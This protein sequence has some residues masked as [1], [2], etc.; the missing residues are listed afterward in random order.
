MPFWRR[1]EPA[2]KKLGRALPNAE[3]GG[4]LADPPDIFGDAISG[5]RAMH[6][7]A[8]PRRWDAVTSVEARD[9]PGDAVHFVALPDGTLLVEE[10]VP[11]DSLGPLADA[12]EATLQPP[13]RAEGVRRGS[14]VWAVAARR[15]RVLELDRDPGG[16]VVGLTVHEGERTLLVDGARTFGSL[17]ELE[18]LLEGDG[19]VHAERLDG[20]L[21]EVTVSPL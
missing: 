18:R 3:A 12:L 15:V 13:Y 6:G 10:D 20:P 7:V 2:H 19:V 16:D 8:R 21:Y 11:D 4:S 17:P 14:A 9:V 1:D 5:E